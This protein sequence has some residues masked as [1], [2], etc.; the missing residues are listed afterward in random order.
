MLQKY[1]FNITKFQNYNLYFKSQGLI[2]H[3]SIIED[4]HF[5]KIIAN[6]KIFNISYYNGNLSKI[7]IIIKSISPVHVV[8]SPIDIE[9]NQIHI[10][11]HLQ[12][13]KNDI[14][15]SYPNLT[16]HQDIYRPCIFYG[17]HSESDYQKLHQN[18]SLKIII[19][20]GSDIYLDHTNANYLAETIKIINK[21]K[22][23][24]KIKH[25]AISKFIEQDLIKLNLEYYRVPFMGIKLQDFEPVKKGKCIYIYT[26]P[27]QGYKY[28]EKIYSQLVKKYQNIKFIFTCSQEGYRLAKKNIYNAKFYNKSDLIKNIYPQCFINL[29]LTKHDGLAAS[30]QELGCMGI[31]SIHNGDSP[32]CLN[33]KTFDDICNHIDNEFKTIGTLDQSLA[34]HVKKYLTLSANFFN[35]K[36]YT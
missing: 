26:S 13:F 5:G 12:H 25:I 19:W 6:R 2:N 15:N 1:I 29:R 8:V 14:F 30:V 32:S 10:A 17:M 21:I 24:T 31:K 9:I 22:L 35:T 11:E 4:T 18:K 3:I 28:G 23:L 34:N 7:S 33:Y 16:P 36:F 20:T 27:I